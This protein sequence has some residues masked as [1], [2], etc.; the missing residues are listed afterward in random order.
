M[1]AVSVIPESA[2][3][4]SFERICYLLERGLPPKPDALAIKN[5]AAPLENWL[6]VEQGYPLM[7]LDR[8]PDASVAAV[9]IE[10][11][12]DYPKVLN[13]LRPGGILFALLP[14]RF[15][16]LLDELW[17]PDCQLAELA[18]GVEEQLDM[19]LPSPD[20]LRAEA[21]AA[22]LVQVDLVA[23]EGLSWL[24]PQLDEQFSRNK[25]GLFD[26]IERCERE[27]EMLGMSR[28]L[29]L[30]GFRPAA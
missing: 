1:S 20:E 8:S 5:L 26:L 30:T 27:P 15:A 11:L 4:L 2:Q 28:Y 24:M 25:Q 13:V 23:V 21:R 22:G 14:A 10:G 19:G 17:R 7:P 9:V 6:A 3:A 29:L 18:D 16:D 12:P